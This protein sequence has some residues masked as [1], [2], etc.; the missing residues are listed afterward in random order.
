MVEN[1]SETGGGVGA[2][3]FALINNAFAPFKYKSTRAS[4][5][6]KT[7]NVCRCA[8]ASSQPES[9]YEVKYVHFTFLSWEQRATMGLGCEYEFRLACIT[10][11]HCAQKFEG[12]GGEGGRAVPYQT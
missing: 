5:Y 7:G 6:L 8:S 11:E 9:E 4:T 2:P 1:K 10:C 3:V 12:G